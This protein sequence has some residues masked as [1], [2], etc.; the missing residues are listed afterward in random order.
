MVLTGP[1]WLKY[2]HA[3]QKSWSGW[4]C[5]RH[6][7]ENVSGKPY[8]ETFL[9][10]DW[11]WQK[12]VLWHHRGKRWNLPFPCPNSPCFT[13]L[14]LKDHGKFI[15]L[16]HVVLLLYHL[17]DRISHH[18]EV[19]FVGNFNLGSLPHIFKAIVIQRML[20]WGEP[21]VMKCRSYSAFQPKKQSKK[22]YKVWSQ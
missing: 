12:W 22:G 11:W 17:L 10:G 5:R 7:C 6:W 1:R 2:G 8:D 16:F 4:P 13:I 3:T 21:S 14:S 15:L 18:P 20:G 9:Q 19:S